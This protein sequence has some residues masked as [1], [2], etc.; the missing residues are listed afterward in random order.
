MENRLS[1]DEMRKHLAIDPETGI[2]TRLIKRQGSPAGSEAGC[3]TKDGY[4]RLRVMGKQF[5][6]HIVAWALYYGEWPTKEIDHA[7]GV[8]DDNRKSNLRLATRAENARNVVS[9][10]MSGHKGVCWVHATKRWL[11]TIGYNGKRKHLGYFRDLD[12]AAEFREL[13]AAMIHGEFASNRVL[14]NG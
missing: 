6:G 11:A 7:N 12:H 13:A 9:S 1:I 5:D 14:S 2:I 3:K 8:R 4:R 10:P